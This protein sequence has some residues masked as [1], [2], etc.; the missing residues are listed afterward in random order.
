VKVAAEFADRGVVLVTVSYDDTAEDAGAF[1]KENGYDF[2]VLMDDRV[3]GVTGPLYQVGPIP[4]LFLID[5]AG[6]I[7]YRRVGYEEGDEEGLQTEIERV[8]NP[9]PA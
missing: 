3:T 5:A 7:T 8:L 2:I 4:T 1:L 6:R 9:P